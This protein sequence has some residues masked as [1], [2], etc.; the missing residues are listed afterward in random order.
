MSPLLGFSFCQDFSLLRLQTLL[1]KYPPEKI[2]PGFTAQDL[3]ELGIK[4]DRSAEILRL[5]D[6]LDLAK[7]QER[8]RRQNIS[9]LDYFQAEY[10]ALLKEIYDPPL[11]LYKKGSLPLADISGVAVVGTRQPDVYGLKATAEVVRALAGQTIV[12]GL[13]LGVDTA[14]HQTALETG[15]PTIAVLGT[16]VDK[17]FPA[18]NYGLYTR[19]CAEQAVISEY[20]PGAPYNKWSFPR[21]N[22]IITGLSRATIVIEGQLTSGALI[23]GKIALEQNREVYALPGQL[24]N[25]LA[26]GPNWLIAQGAK[27]LYD[28]EILRQEI[29]GEQLPLV[30]S[31][32][33]YSPTA[34]EAKIYER[35][36]ADG[37][38]ALDTLLEYFDLAF[39]SKT[40]LQMEMKGMISVL[41][42]KQIVRI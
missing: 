15:A 31:K 34:D 36:P 16:P 8:L 18:S 30:F 9:V 2:W 40:L 42:G 37:T 14:A 28:L 29:C 38:V 26:A 10:P 41:P 7:Y 6:R 33:A 13:A 23:S 5:R 39:L 27:P 19:L 12:S 25:P 11:V 35:L 21:R 1:K 20:P 3:Q 17:C 32:P 24:G 4:A 22:R